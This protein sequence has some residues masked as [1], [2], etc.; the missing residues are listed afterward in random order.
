MTA[1]CKRFA[2]R[3]DGLVPSDGIRSC[4]A[5]MTQDQG[6]ASTLALSI[7]GRRLTSADRFT[8]LKSHMASEPPLGLA[9]IG[10]GISRRGADKSWSFER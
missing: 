9:I 3:A 7:R 5:P 6:N 8:D 1:A 4:C 2:A 10:A